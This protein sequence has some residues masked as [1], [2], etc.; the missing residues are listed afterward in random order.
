MGWGRVGGIVGEFTGKYVYGTGNMRVEY[1]Y[2]RVKSRGRGQWERTNARWRPLIARS[3][4][5]ASGSWRRMAAPK[6]CGVVNLTGAANSALIE[7]AANLA[8]L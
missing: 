6:G 3:S 7:M 8:G 4:P 2:I 1:K 5:A